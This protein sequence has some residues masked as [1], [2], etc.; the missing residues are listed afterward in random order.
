METSLLG[1]VLTMLD[2]SKSGAT[3]AGVLS[4]SYQSC[5]MAHIS[6]DLSIGNARCLLSS[7]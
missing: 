4:M 2:F 6:R 3:Y 7:M 5:L 1:L